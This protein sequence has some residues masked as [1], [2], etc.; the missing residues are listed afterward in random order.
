MSDQVG[1]MQTE[2]RW[3]ELSRQKRDLDRQL[4]EISEEMEALE[5]ELVDRWADQGIKSMN[6]DGDTLFVQREFFARSKE[7]VSRAEVVAILGQDG[8]T[9]LLMPAHQTIRSIVRE[10]QESGLPIPESIQRCFEVGDTFRLRHRC[11]S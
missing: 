1:T 5:K 4:R 8:Y 9:D 11:G 2:K 6:L 7:G 10:A 3:L